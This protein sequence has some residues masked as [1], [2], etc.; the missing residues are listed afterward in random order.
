MKHDDDSLMHKHARS[1]AAVL[2]DDNYIINI[3]TFVIAA[4]YLSFKAAAKNLCVTPGAVSHR[5]ARL[6]E[7]LGFPLF[8]RLTRAVTLTTEGE[9]LR[10][11]YE[12]ALSKMQSEICRLL[13]RDGLKGLTIF[14]HP[15]IAL[16]WLIPRLPQL[17]AANPT[18]R[19]TVRTGNAPADFSHQSGI[20]VALYYSNGSFTG[21][22]SRK[23]MDECCV[24]VCTPAYAEA[25]DLY[26]HPENLGSCTLLHDAAPWHY[27]TDNAEWQ[28]WAGKNDLKLERVQTMTFDSAYATALAASQ[29]LGV[30]MGRTCLM[31]KLLEEKL[32]VMPFPQLSPMTTSHAYYAVWPRTRRPSGVLQTFLQWLMDTAQAES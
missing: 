24:P 25:H 21:L 8:N 12:A 4:R 11:V 17:H 18:L 32:L 23:F 27:S 6:E 15:S 16:G 7:V 13:D 3:K 2:V 29:G 9:R 30:A 26:G 31:K 14:A 10:G 20:D 22:Q 28:E 5:I 1:I 19:L